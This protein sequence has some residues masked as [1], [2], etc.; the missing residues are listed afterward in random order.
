MARTDACRTRA[1]RVPC[2]A[3]AACAACHPQSATADAQASVASFLDDWGTD[4]DS[5]APRPQLQVRAAR[6]ARPRPSAAVEGAVWPGVLDTTWSE[7]QARP[8]QPTPMPAQ[9]VKQH[10]APS[11]PSRVT[12]SRLSHGRGQAAAG[13]PTRREEQT[14]HPCSEWGN[15]V[16]EIYECVIGAGKSHNVRSAPG[17]AHPVVGSLKR[18]QRVATT[19]AMVVNGPYL[20]F[21]PKLSVANQVEEW[22]EIQ[23]SARDA[24]GSRM[25][26][27][28]GSVNKIHG[29]SNKIHVLRT[30]IRVF[31]NY[32]KNTT[33]PLVF[34]ILGQVCRDGRCRRVFHTFQEWQQLCR[35][36]AHAFPAKRC[37]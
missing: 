8:C 10:V 29:S 20:I 28:G 33:P 30:K 2:A 13:S 19:I 32:K 17:S 31:F 24:P 27:T 5:A 15:D 6:P 9:V 12:P 16:G 3:C 7:S 35:V 18:G 34:S 1:R 21:D 36:Y 22:L 14:P 4:G 37:T 25:L 11:L 23:G 26:N